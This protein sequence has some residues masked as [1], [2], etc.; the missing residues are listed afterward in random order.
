MKVEQDPLPMQ[1]PTMSVR[2]TV[3]HSLKNQM[4]EYLTHLKQ[5]DNMNLYMSF[6]DKK[7]NNPSSLNA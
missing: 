7:S 6:I 2:E 5:L 3:L 1:I 4:E